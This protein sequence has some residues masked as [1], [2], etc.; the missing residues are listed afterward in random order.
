MT[1]LI[2]LEMVLCFASHAESLPYERIDDRLAAY[3]REG[4][5]VDSEALSRQYHAAVDPATGETVMTPPAPPA[6]RVVH[7]ETVYTHTPANNGSGPFWSSGCTTLARVGDT[8]VLSEMETGPDVPL[9]CNTRW[10]LHARTENGWRLLAEADGYRQREPAVLATTGPEAFYLYVNDSTEPPGTKYGPCTPYLLKFNLENA[11]N[12][13]TLR[14]V[15]EGETT[16]TDHSYRGYAADRDVQ[17]LLMLNIDAKTSEQNWCHMNANGEVLGNG[18]ITFPIRSCYPQAALKSGAAYVL[19]VGDIREPVTE[20]ADYKFEQ[21]KSSWDYV[22]RILY[23]TWTPDLRSQGFAPA[24][25]IANVDATAGHVFGQD[26]YVTPGGDAY[27]MYTQRPVSTPLM[28]DRFFPD[29]SIMDSL[30]LAVVRGGQV[31][32]RKVLL[33]GTDTRQPGCARFHVAANGDLYALVYA[34]I[35]G[36]PGNYLMPVNP[37]PDGPSL[38]PIPLQQ[39]TSSFLLASPRAGNAPSNTIDLVGAGPANSIVYAQMALEQ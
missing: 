3:G 6:V 18:K 16:F 32:E 39:P 11:A 35:D 25:E 36:A 8:V 30:H 12:P 5:C 9:L 17:E 31:I 24:I 20:W 4:R 22:F 2:L 29:L 7:E 23:F 27:V 19:A 21:T 28:R 37:P 38:I 13:Q 33:E 10:R 26:L 15:W 14:P 34:A 1:S